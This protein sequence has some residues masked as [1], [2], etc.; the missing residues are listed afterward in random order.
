MSTWIASD[1]LE[2]YVKKDSED[3][4][5]IC[6]KCYDQLVMPIMGSWKEWVSVLRGFYP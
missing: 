6:R 2:F 5:E 1:C 3:S 4:F